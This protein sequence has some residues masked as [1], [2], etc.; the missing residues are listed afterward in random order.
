[1]KTAPPSAAVGSSTV[2]NLLAFLEKGIEKVPVLGTPVVEVARGVSQLR[3]IG[4]GGREAKNAL[5]TP[6]T[7]ALKEGEAK[8]KR[9]KLLGTTEQLDP[10]LGP[11]S[12]MGD[13]QRKQM[14]EQQLIDALSSRKR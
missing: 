4:A 6:L 13:A 14:Q 10:S 1:V 11:M 5:K 12:L 8:A 9:S 7:E 3:K 2:Q